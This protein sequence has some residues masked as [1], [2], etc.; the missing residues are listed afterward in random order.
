MIDSK[1]LIG[2]LFVQQGD[3]TQME[4][5][6][7]VN[8]ANPSL[9]GGGGVDGAIHRAAGPKLL[10]ECRT[11]GGCA[12]GEARI[13]KGYRLKAKYII[14]TPGPVYKNGTSGER[15]VLGNSYLNSMRLALEYKLTSIAF[16]AISTGVY[17]YPRGEACEVAVTTVLGFMKEMEYMM[18]VVF[19][20]FDNENFRI[21]SD[22]ITGLK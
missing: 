21:Y 7:I 16:P 12:H 6:A 19:V 8:A 15:E 3:I 18:S 1:E 5:D 11:L 13:T 14:H 9:M 20:L 22:F 10:E 17:G 4:V 2:R